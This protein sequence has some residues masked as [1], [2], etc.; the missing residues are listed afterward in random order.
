MPN[1]NEIILQILERSGLDRKD[2]HSLYRYRVTSEELDLLRRE[3]KFHFDSRG[4][5]YA[6]TA[7]G[8]ITL[9]RID[10]NTGLLLSS[11]DM[12]VGIG[13]LSFQPGTDVLF[14][15]SQAG[16]LYTIDVTTGA[17]TLVGDTTTKGPAVWV[18]RRTAHFTSSITIAR[19]SRRPNRFRR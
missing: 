17:E 6:T 11:I 7:R 19:S 13:D 14:G 4:N 12:S 3:L 15:I 5:L 1:S 8:G 18:L 16:V 10:P 2:G 9:K